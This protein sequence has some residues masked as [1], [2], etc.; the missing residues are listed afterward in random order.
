MIQFGAWSTFLALGSIHGLI[1]AGLL[2]AS[3]RNMMANRFL[4][5]LLIGAVLMITPYTIGYAGFYDA[6]PWLTFAP[7][8][9]QLAF[10][11]LLYFY[12]RQLGNAALPP[13][14][15]LHF[16]PATIQGAYY[17]I[18]FLLPL[19][20]KWDWN[21]TG[22]D[23]YVSPLLNVAILISLSVYWW[24]A[25][26]RYR[27]YQAWLEAN[28]ARREDL[29]LGW[30][31]GFLWA[32]AAVV[33][34]NAGFQTV[35][36]LIA[37][38]NY[39]DYFPFYIALSLLVYYLGIEGWR[40]AGLTLPTMTAAIEP[41][42]EPTEDI[43]TEDCADAGTA[44]DTPSA[45]AAATLTERNWRALGERW[46]SQVAAAGWWQEPD[47]SLADLARRLGT[48]TQ[49]L[50]RAL[51]DGLGQSFS[52]FVNRLRVEEAKRRLASATD[53]DITTIA[54]EVGFGSKASFNRAFRAIVGTTP[55][56]YRARLEMR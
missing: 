29:H 20:M 4:A 14:W 46:S 27:A 34:L 50:S 51:N 17:I 3:K 11:P 18:A 6:Y 39:F 10:G 40:H 30:L 8:Y 53:T 42:A 49:Y 21:Q 35:D 5:G 25:F 15:R 37:P 36:R 13:R 55:S 32:V 33:A 1:V 38:L 48:N 24:L 19:Q 22:H 43:G 12:V 2:L 23:R 28:S 16:V 31:R 7:F 54:L 9:W 26:R 56:D 44:H 47:L 52:Q 45:K 41:I